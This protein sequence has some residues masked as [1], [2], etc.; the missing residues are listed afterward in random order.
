MPD[1]TREPVRIAQVGVRGFGRIHLERID[2]VRRAGRAELVAV[3]DPAGPLDAL[4]VSWYPTLTELLAA[5]AVDVVSIATPISTHL[6]LAVEAMEA[7]CHVFLE[8]PPVPSLA[9]FWRLLR[10]QKDTGRVVQIGFQSLGSTGIHRLRD[11]MASGSLGEV[12]S[13]DAYGA[14]VRP[15]SYYARAAWAGKRTLDGVAVA[16]GVVTNPLAHAVATACAVG[17][18]T[19]LDDLDSVVTE[20]YHAHDIEADDTSYVQLRRSAEVPITAALTLCAPEQTDPV[21]SVVGSRGR[22]DFSYTTDDL[23]LVIDGI[24]TREQASRT[25]LLVNLL[26]HLDDPSVAVLC[27]PVATVGF[28]AVLE[29]TQRRSAPV[30]IATAYVDWR[31]AASDPNPVVAEVTT[32]QRAAL[33]AGRTFVEVGAPWAS[34]DAVVVWR[35]R[36]ALASLSLPDGTMVAEYADGSDIQPLSSPRPYLH[37]LRTRSGVLVSDSHPADHDWHCGLSLTMQDVNGVNF[38]GGRTF[39]RDRGYTWLGDQGRIDHVDFE[40]QGDARL[41]EVLRWHGPDPSVARDDVDQPAYVELREDRTLSWRS[42]SDRAWRLDADLTLTPVSTHR[43]LLGGPGTNGR[44]VGYG[45]WQLRLGP[46]RDPRVL[47]PVGDDVESVF[48]ERAP[49]VG[50][51]ATFPHGAHDRVASVVMAGL[52]ADSKTDRWFVR[53]AEFLGIGTALAWSE[54]V[55]ATREVPLRRRYALIVADGDVTASDVEEW[56]T[57]AGGVV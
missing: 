34:E 29:A 2:A 23:L 32:W 42:I 13:I 26:D 45:G 17:G 36:T 16:D 43:V 47:S 6:S 50:V 24:E 8:K 41:R 11:L 22:A 30:A 53:T 20:L 28:M 35:P 19:R 1:S 27:P 55:V 38:W 9:D 5:E 10:V 44:D 48:G 56:L 57:T 39:V 33:A 46:G 54:P 31:H 18:V 52:D 3:A 51:T 40:E 15:R 4:G 25:D 14:W 37:P 12:R 49:W 7:G 21:V